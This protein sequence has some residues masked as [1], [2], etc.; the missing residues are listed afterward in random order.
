M[1]LKV[2]RRERDTSWNKTQNDQNAPHTSASS[3]PSP[4]WLYPSHSAVFGR[5]RLFLHLKSVA[6]LHSETVSIIAA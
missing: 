6:D 5:H 4:Q 1:N 2:E 3:F